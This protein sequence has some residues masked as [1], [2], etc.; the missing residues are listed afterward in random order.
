MK[1]VRF[2][3]MGSEKPGLIDKAGKLRDLSAHVKDLAGDTPP[4]PACRY[5]PSRSSS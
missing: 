3:A 1:F 2:G 4:K 5:R